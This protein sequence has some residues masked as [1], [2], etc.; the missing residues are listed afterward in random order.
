MRGWLRRPRAVL[1]GHTS[2]TSPGGA[3]RSVTKGTIFV[4]S[5]DSGVGEEASACACRARL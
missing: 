3:A 2:G 4:A 5:P 1:G